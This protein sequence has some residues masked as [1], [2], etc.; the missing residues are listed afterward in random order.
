MLLVRTHNIAKDTHKLKVKGW[1][2]IFHAN[3]NKKVRVVILISYNID[4]KTNNKRQGHYIMI[5]GSIQK[6]KINLLT[7]MH[8]I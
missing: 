3:R 1:K 4:L 2:K 7:S 5:K 6:E 8:P